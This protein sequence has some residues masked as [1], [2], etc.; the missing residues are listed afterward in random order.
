MTNYSR[1]IY[2]YFVNPGAGADHVLRDEAGRPPPARPRL[3]QARR[4]TRPL[5]HPAGSLPAPC[6]GLSRSCRP[7]RIPAESP[8]CKRR[9]GRACTLPAPARPPPRRYRGP[10]LEGGHVVRAARGRALQR[11]A[12]AQVVIG[13]WDVGCGMWHVA[14]GRWDVA[15]GM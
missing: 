2:I 13:G 4:G 14:C 3:R 6:S 9:W 11:M 7:C 8:S 15:C 12:R 1:S 5:W 10:S